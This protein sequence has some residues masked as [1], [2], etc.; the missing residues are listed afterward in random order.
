[1]ASARVVLWALA[2]QL[3]MQSRGRRRQVSRELGVGIFHNLQRTQTNFASPALS[4]GEIVVGMVLQW[5]AREVA[6]RVDQQIVTLALAT[7]ASIPSQ[8]KC[9]RLT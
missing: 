3:A 1:M 2:V 6:M 8:M 4:D 9:G 7:Q 5:S